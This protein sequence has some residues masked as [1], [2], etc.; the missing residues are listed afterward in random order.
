MNLHYADTRKITPGL[1]PDGSPADNDRM[2]I[3]P[4]PLAFQEW[5]DAGLEA[6]NLTIMRQAR[7]DRLCKMLQERDYGGIL[8]FDPLNIRYASDSTNMQLWNAHNPFRACFVSASGHMILWDFKGLGGLLTSHNPLIKE[9]RAGSSSFFYFSN[10]DKTKERAMA[11]A[12]EID[13]EMRKHAGSNRRLA[14]DK[15]MVHGLRAFE[16][17]GLEIMEGEEVTEKARVVKSPEEIKAMRCAVHACET[18]VR[19]MEEAVEP[20]MT[21]DDVWAVLHAENIRRGGEWIETRLMASGPR[22]NPWFQECGPRVLQEGDILGF[23]TDL[24]GCYGLCTDMSRTWVVGDAM[25]TQ[26][27]IDTYRMSVE[28]IETNTKLLGPGVPFRELTMGGHKLPEEF[29]PQRYGAKMH[30]VGLCDEW[31][32]ITYPEDWE[33]GVFDYDCE[34]GMMFCVEIYAG[35]VGGSFG[36]KLEDQVLVTAD[37]HEVLTKYHWDERLM[38]R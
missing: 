34:E 11:F 15:I 23:D 12:Q 16:A 8:M 5:A 29:V 13:A 33:R 37:G 9:T 32:L 2:E 7:L 28:H 31:P 1:R 6:P 36:I 4:T 21:E 18:S 35:K 19:I 14:V 27:Q 26:E 38:G 17:I 30:G 22:T 10:G 25:P 24:V 3:G 20:G